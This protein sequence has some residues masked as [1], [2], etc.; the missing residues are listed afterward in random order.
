MF[1]WGL[2]K[3]SLMRRNKTVPQ[4]FYTH[5]RGVSEPTISIEKDAYYVKGKKDPQLRS[6]TV[7]A[8]L[9]KM[10]DI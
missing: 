2:S 3:S 4:S 9:R 6:F 8:I 10:N 5:V 1:R 7:C